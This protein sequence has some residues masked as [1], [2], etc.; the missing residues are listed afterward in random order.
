MVVPVEEQQK[1]IR[2]LKETLMNGERFF[3]VINMLN[4][5]MEEAHGIQKWLGYGQKE[6]SL[7]EY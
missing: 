1:E 7:R 5:E 3:F 6:F 4:F 2:L